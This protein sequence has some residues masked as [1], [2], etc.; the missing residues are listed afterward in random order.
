M[1]KLGIDVATRDVKKL[2]KNL[3]RLKTTEEVI[4]GGMYHQDRAISQIHLTTKW[5]EEKLEE[6]LYRVA[7]GCEYV[8]TFER[9]ET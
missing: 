2:M 3:E 8:G 5:D 7:H 9:N 6:W 1:N 4:D